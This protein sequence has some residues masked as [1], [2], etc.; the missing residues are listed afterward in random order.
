MATLY[1]RKLYDTLA[2]VDSDAAEAMEKIKMNSIVK[3]E[4]TKPR[5]IQFLRKY[6]ALLNHAYDH[7]EPE[8]KEYRGQPVQKNRE[9]FRKEITIL[10]GFYEAVYKID[11]TFKLVAKSISF[12]NMTED[13]FSNLYSKTIS[14]ILEKVLTSY[15]EDD[16]NAV[17]DQI[18]SFD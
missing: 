2:P 9:V 5:N 10:S 8:G 13:E 7:F 11:G 1:L 6:F 18:L 16:L 17:V 15:A 3:C 14:V 4:I 12:A